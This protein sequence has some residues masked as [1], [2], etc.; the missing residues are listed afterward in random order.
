MPKSFLIK[1]GREYG[2]LSTKSCLQKEPTVGEGERCVLCLQK[3]YLITIFL[4][5]FLEARS[6]CIFFYL[7]V[8][9]LRRGLPDREIC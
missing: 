2:N 4:F 9:F 6:F 8:S 3:I 7:N 1:K 5:S